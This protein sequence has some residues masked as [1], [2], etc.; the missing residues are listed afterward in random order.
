MVNGRKA[1]V[2]AMWKSFLTSAKPG[3]Y[4][5]DPMML[6]L[7]VFLEH[8]GKDHKTY[9]KARNPTTAVWY[10]FLTKGQFWGFSGS[11]GPFQS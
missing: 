4:M 5:D 7:S 9:P 10:A 2:V 8:I 11:S 3:V 1:A 6:K